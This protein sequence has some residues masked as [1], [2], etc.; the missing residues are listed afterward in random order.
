MRPAAP[1]FLALLNPVQNQALRLA[2]GAFRS[3]PVPS[4]EV[5]MNVMS[6]DLRR[7][8]I[9]VRSFF[10]EQV[11]PTSHLRA[12]FTSEGFPSSPW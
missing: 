3:F 9:A 6:L 1:R 11:L 8:L 7:E 2:S 5:E 4:L 10:Q 12:L